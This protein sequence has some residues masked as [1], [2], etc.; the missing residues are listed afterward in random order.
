[1]VGSSSSSNSSSN[2]NS[3]N[4]NS[5]SNSS[6]STSALPPKRPP[7]ARLKRTTRGS[8]S[9]EN[10]NRGR[11]CGSVWWCCYCSMS[12]GTVL[13]TPL[14][15]RK[16]LL[17]PYCGAPMQGKV[18]CP[19]P[20]PRYH[21]HHH[22]LP[23]AHHSIHSHPHKLS[24]LTIFFLTSPLSASM[25]QPLKDTQTISKTE[26]MNKVFMKTVNFTFS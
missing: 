16:V 17:R 10:I 25:F 15:V 21:A 6:S 23:L 7:A 1:M 3:S 4:S 26:T 20:L 12:L 9:H 2:I 18:C 22:P 11:G 8:S 13:S 24:F 19:F 5:S 14:A